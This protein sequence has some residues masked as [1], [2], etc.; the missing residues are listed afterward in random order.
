MRS[1]DQRDIA[2]F[3]VASDRE[4]IRLK[5][6][7]L[8][9]RS[10]TVRP[11]WVLENNS[12]FV[13]RD[14]AGCPAIFKCIEEI[15]SN[16]Y[17]N[18]ERVFAAKSKTPVLNI[19]VRHD[20]ATGMITVANDGDGIPVIRSPK[21][22]N[23]YIPDGIFS[24]ARCG[25]NIYKEDGSTLGG[26]NGYGAKLTIFM[27]TFAEVKTTDGA[28]GLT[29]AK[30]FAD[31]LAVGEPVVAPTKAA[32]GTQVRF[33]L[34]WSLFTQNEQPAA[35]TPAVAHGIDTFLTRWLKLLAYAIHADGR[36]CTVTYNDANMYDAGIF[37]RFG[38]EPI[39]ITH[40]ADGTKWTYVVS[41]VS[42]QYKIG[43]INGVYVRGEITTIERLLAS[44]KKHMRTT[45]KATFG[46]D[47]TTT[48]LDAILG[49]ISVCF[50][51]RVRG[52]EWNAQNKDTAG[53]PESELAR[54][55]EVTDRQLAQIWK[56]V[57]PLVVD[58][59]EAK[60]TRTVKYEKYEPAQRVK[61]DPGKCMLLIVEGKS[62]A[63]ATRDGLKNKI[64]QKR[65]GAMVP[66]IGLFQLKGVPINA[67]RNIKYV[68]AGNRQLIKQTDKLKNNAEINGLISALGAEIGKTYDDSVDG[69]ANRGRLNYGRAV[70]L[71]DQD[72]DATNIQS[73]T[74]NNVR[75]LCRGLVESNS[76]FNIVY[77][78]LVRVYLAK[79][80]HEFYTEDAFR[81]WCSDNPTA[82]TGVKK[83]AVK[84][85]KGLASNNG[86][87]RIKICMNIFERCYRMHGDWPEFDK[88][89]GD[90]PAMRRTLVNSPVLVFDCE[91][92]RDISVYMHLHSGQKAFMKENIERKLPSPFDGLVPSRRKAVAVAKS[93]KARAYGVDVI[94]GEALRN[95]EYHHGAASLISTLN[96]M[97]QV[98]VGAN[99]VPFYLPEGQS[100][101]NDAGGADSGQSRYVKLMPN[102]GVLSA[103][104]PAA[105]ADL[106]PY[107]LSDGIKVEPRHYLPILPPVLE[108]RITVAHGWNCA[109]YARDLT[110]VVKAVHDKIAGKSV[111]GRVLPFWSRGG[112]DIQI[113][114][115]RE[116]S[117]GAFH[118]E[119]RRGRDW[120]VITKLPYR[121][122]RQQYIAFLKKLLRGDKSEMHE[123]KR[124]SE[125]AS[126]EPGAKKKGGRGGNGDAAAP[127][128][129]ASAAPASTAPKPGGRA[130]VFDTIENAPFED[131]ISVRLVPA[132]ADALD[133]VYVAD[134]PT[135]SKL[136]TYF[137]LY[138]DMRP[139][140]NFYDDGVCEYANYIDVVEAWFPKRHALY[141]QR[142]ERENML[143]TCRAIELRELIRYCGEYATLRNDMHAITE[144]ADIAMLAAAGFKKLNT[145]VLAKHGGMLAD[146]IMAKLTGPKASFDY[147]RNLRRRD[148][149]MERNAER[150]RELADIERKLQ[151]CGGSGGAPIGD[152]VARVWRSE[153][154]T[155]VGEIKKGM[156]MDWKTPHDKKL[157]DSLLG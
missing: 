130:S 101:T 78:A 52:V 122:W 143:L 106:L 107:V 145:G 112:E 103:M 70:L 59:L 91:P 35:Y 124:K 22:D 67:S 81:R 15:I 18:Y 27:S 68:A 137:Q 139:I 76:F 62:A 141:C 115:G 129:N 32:A 43:I 82:L 147:I 138:T 80:I 142:I 77:T 120:L 2:A 55:G 90:D 12:T 7:Y 119:Q 3:D 74:I 117:M 121:C 21:Y 116:C 95:F 16:A 64:F 71:T 134:L 155:L 58:M 105:D 10:I 31:G 87:E 100:G 49:N 140:L 23:L 28:R 83:D 26:T 125:K 45:I 4:H 61:T 84:Y 46:K 127:A 40:T 97:S 9:K 53:V 47:V 131:R 73:L 39:Y 98:F 108:T 51:G 33:S 94:C 24:M 102:L 132:Y 148:L 85:V 66:Y 156:A 63:G 136:R 149:V 92:T 93:L 146:A 72:I 19:R 128:L 6:M 89:L 38:S 11:E 79:H 50:I 37:A 96:K 8:G 25:S 88:F 42:P 30:Q 34:D 111:R 135:E 56:L 36:R 154:Q 17:D 153:I 151:E 104:F 75:R 44:V 48:Q 99:N 150:Q 65:F 86:A 20:R 123:L 60:T 118:I 114:N 13:S 29:F 133:K 126:A 41:L 144:Q 14:V 1:R 157:Y 113:V 5:S 152:I 110:A 54:F 109:I 69:V 57:E